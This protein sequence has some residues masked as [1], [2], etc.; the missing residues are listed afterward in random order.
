MTRRH[1][2]LVAILAMAPYRAAAQVACG[3]TIGPGQA[4]ILTGD[5]G[6]CPGPEPALTVIGP[7]T[8]DLAGFT[9]SC[10][11]T[12]GLRV[13]GRAAKILRGTIGFCSP[14]LEIAGDGRHALT[15]VLASGGGDGFVVT[16][17][18]NKLTRVTSSDSDGDWGFRVQG[19]G[20]RC[21]GCAAIDGSEGIVVE[22]ARNRF[23]GVR[24]ADN[25]ETGI[26]LGGEGNRL[27]GCHVSFSDYTGIVV[28]GNANRVERC[29]VT[30]NGPFGGTDAGIEV[31]GDGNRISSND[32]VN[33][34]SF[35][36]VLQPGATG[37]LVSKNLVLGHETP[38]GVD[39]R[40]A[41][42]PGCGGNVWTA[43]VFGTSDPVRAS[44][45]GCIE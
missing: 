13:E 44:A 38:E 21:V 9:L 29:F 35:G 17:D 18:K 37:N 34:P 1:L 42:G 6:P 4:V 32:V 10:V 43:N 3:D 23:D 26:V 33:D 25:S 7:A 12:P 16:S 24:A 41:N 8:L 5:L 15:A 31:T 22:G 27:A 45:P 14:A 19:D 2:F 36:I 28:S 20:N 39:L 40:D 11:G 30:E